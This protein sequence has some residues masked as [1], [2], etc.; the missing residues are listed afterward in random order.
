MAPNSVCW[1]ITSKCNDCCAF[2]Y[3]EKNSCELDFDT[4]KKVID[5]IADA[6]IKKLT[7]AGG[8]PLLVSRINE[9]ILYTK[10]NGLL[11]SMTTNG[12]L[13][14][15]QEEE[16]RFLFRHLDWLT[17]SLDGA[18][19]RIQSEMGRNSNHLK[20]V[21][22]ILT[23]AQND[24][25][26]KCKIKINTVVSKVN[27]EHI[28]S[29]FE[30]FKKYPIDRWKL[31]QFTPVRGDAIKSQKKYLILDNEFQK[32]V[33]E[34]RKKMKNESWILSVSERE[35]IESAYFVIFPNGDIRI[36]DRHNDRVI[37][38]VLENDIENIWEHGGFKKELHKERTECV[39]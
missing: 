25:D 34:I 5:K 7:F 29:M 9:L 6:D 20:R 24:S 27:Q 21:L 2:C 22:S 10:K 33:D 31:F 32:V 14:E 3:R 38:N 8:E 35:N 11:T 23:M 30:L 37:G 26:R 4:Q 15:K 17:L 19:E 36:S 18:N 1:N 28:F 13:L 39:L 16:C 12:I